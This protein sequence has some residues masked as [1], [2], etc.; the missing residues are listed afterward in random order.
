LVGWLLKFYCTLS[1]AAFNNDKTPIPGLNL[2]QSTLNSMLSL[3][4][5]RR[6]DRVADCAA[7]EMLCTREGTQGSNP[8]LSASSTLSLDY[9]RT[10]SRKYEACSRSTS[11]R[12]L[13]D[14]GV[15]KYA[16]GRQTRQVVE[17]EVEHDPH[18]QQ[19]ARE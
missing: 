11:C 16:W 6:G 15:L 13:T 17:F 10:S 4:P 1:S 7:L 3:L 14:T 2:M 19:M 5:P 18:L 9:S 12:G 8:C